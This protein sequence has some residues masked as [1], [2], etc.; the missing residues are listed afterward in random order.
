MIIVAEVLHTYLPNGMESQD[1][2]GIGSILVHS[3]THAD[4]AVFMVAVTLVILAIAFLN[5]FI[6]QKLLRFSERF[7]FE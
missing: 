4:T 7:R 3:S 5:F 2:F 6:W 1:L